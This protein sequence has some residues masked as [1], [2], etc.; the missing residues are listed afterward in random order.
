MSHILADSC[1][2]SR[3]GGLV[4]FFDCRSRA[5]VGADSNMHYGDGIRVK[6]LNG[7]SHI[8]PQKGVTH[9]MNWRL[10]FAKSLLYCILALT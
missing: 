8:S 2:L 9:A 10:D 7:L 5:G 4:R 1:N 3:I 6:R